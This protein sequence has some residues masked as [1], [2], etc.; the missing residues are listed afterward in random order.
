LLETFA[1][2]DLADPI[3][4]GII[5]VTPDSFSDGGEVFSHDKAIRRGWDM[6]ASGA[7]ILDVGG[8]STRPGADP[9]GI[10]E[11]IRRVVPVIEALR[12]GAAVI[13]I[14][15]RHPDVMVAAVEAGAGV[16]NDVTALSHDERSVRTVR[17]LGVPVILMHMQGNP[18]NMQAAPSYENAPREIRDYLMERISVCLEAGITREH[19]AVDPGIGFGKTLEHNLQILHRIDI[20]SGLAGPIVLGVSRKSFIA[21]VSGEDAP[22]KR[23]SGSLAAA[24]L[25]RQQGVQIFRVHDV[26]ETVQALSI[27]DAILRQHA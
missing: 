27:A 19:I 4:M 25:A 15:T 2:L 3:V 11:E 16:V 23:V 9:V 22:R 17:E 24:V 5:N 20:L 7:A 8:E 21:S 12:G 13:S 26:E 6:I 10:D 1:G 18:E 14:D